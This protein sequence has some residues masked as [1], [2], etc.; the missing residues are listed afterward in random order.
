MFKK[1]NYFTNQH[2]CFLLEYHL[3][4]VTKYRNKVF[5]KEMT[6]GLI[7]Y[8]KRYFKERR[9][10]IVEINVDKDHIHILFYSYPNINLSQYINAYK[11]GSS[12]YLRKNYEEYLKEFYWENK[13]WSNSYFICGVSERSEEVVKEYI[14]NQGNDN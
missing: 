3:V 12:R 2:S 6:E 10:K 8:T 13:F 14:K 1:G 9:L 5:N 11:S 7:N 4:L